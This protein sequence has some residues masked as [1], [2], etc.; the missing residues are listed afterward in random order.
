MQLIATEIIKSNYR[1]LKG[2]Q[3][4]KE[5]REGKSLE[6]ILGNKENIYPQKKQ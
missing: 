4:L 1:Y 6:I 3:F 2:N 5:G